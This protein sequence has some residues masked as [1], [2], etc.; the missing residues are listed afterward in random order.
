MT[1][2][3]QA[4]LFSTAIFL[5][6]LVA[7]WRIETNMAGLVEQ[8]Q[9]I[10]G[11]WKPI[12]ALTYEMQ[13]DVLQVQ[14]WLTDISATRGRDGLNDGYDEA[15]AAAQRFMAKI[16]QLLE[17]YP[18][19]AEAIKAL[20]APFQRY[21]EVGKKMAAAY[22]EG[23][24]AAGN[25]MMG[26]FDAGA[27][28]MHEALNRFVELSSAATNQAF[29]TEE[30]DIIKTERIVLISFTLLLGLIA[31]FMY[32]GN[33][34]II[35]PLTQIKEF[36]E[37]AVSQGRFSDRFRHS[38]NDEI[39]VMASSLNRLFDDVNVLMTEANKALSDVEQGNLDTQIKAQLKGDLDDL[40][41]GINRTIKE[42]YLFSEKQ[43]AA[44]A[45]LQAQSEALSQQ[46]E[47]MEASARELAEQNQVASQRNAALNAASANIVMLDNSDKV[48]F[49]NR[50]A[51]RFFGQYETFFASVDSGFNAARLVGYQGANWFYHQQN[52]SGFGSLSAAQ[53]FELSGQ[54]VHLNVVAVPV[55]AENNTRLGTVLEWRDNTDQVKALTQ[56]SEVVNAVSEGNLQVQVNIESGSEF[57]VKLGES[58]NQLICSVREV[59]SAFSA[60][61]KELESGNLDSDIRADM[62][63]EYAVIKDSTNHMLDVWREVLRNVSS[64]CESVRQGAN[65]IAQSTAQLSSRAEQQAA[66]L[67]ESN[68]NM[69]EIAT[70]V[71][72]YTSISEEGRHIADLLKDKTQNGNQVI[73]NTAS[74]MND[75]KSSSNKI[76]EIITVI[77]EIAFQTNLLALNAAVEAARAGESGRGFAVVAGEVRHLAQR[78][79]NAAKEIS[80]LITDTVEKVEAGTELADKSSK[81]L[82]EIL[83]MV[84]KM[85]GMMIKIQASAKEQNSS[86]NEISTAIRQLD[87]ITQQNAGNADRVSHDSDALLKSSESL[88]SSIA[89]FRGY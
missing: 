44:N 34:K 75:I 10:T 23:G 17:L 49:L 1:I 15:E 22:I 38:A 54:G 11:K 42:M 89:F 74:A 78:A 70:M 7:G 73:G 39:G 88:E 63:G 30:L 3:K 25:K 76:S 16:D 57:I 64:L 4:A 86:V 60:T 50:S 56:I 2:K 28:S 80:E 43:K 32:Q 27:E 61:F 45:E 52:F 59:M 18:E 87:H 84:E 85:N 69:A 19:Q 8:S 40:K 35:K 62:K 67:E 24:P 21:Y 13:L 20:V 26:E 37:Q 83:D 31:I 53:D 51:E 14:Q 71:Q 9:Q 82:Y 46:Q 29:Q 47:A 58:L 5:I 36:I 33:A 41:N 65:G 66:S 77:N 79:A 12:S 81:T 55:F 48:V 6:I 72:E 68:A